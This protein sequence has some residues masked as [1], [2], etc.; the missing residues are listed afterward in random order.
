MLRRNVRDA[1]KRGSAPRGESR[2]VD[3]AFP[4]DAAQAQGA[5]ALV[6]TEKDAVKLD[7]DIIMVLRNA[8]IRNHVGAI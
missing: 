5:T 1:R 8:Q 7:L 6:T 2:P 3:V 4:K